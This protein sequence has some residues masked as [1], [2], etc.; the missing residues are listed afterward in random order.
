MVLHYYFFVH[1]FLSVPDE[2]QRSADGYYVVVR[3]I[4]ITPLGEGK[5]T[6]VGLCQALAAFLDKK[7]KVLSV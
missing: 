2:L 5:S 1:F 7:I 3:E 4:N 6:P